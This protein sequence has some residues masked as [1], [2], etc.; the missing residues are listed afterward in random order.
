MNKDKGV[1]P[2]DQSWFWTEE[3]QEGER[4]ASEEIREGKLSPRLY[5]MEEME[6]YLSDRK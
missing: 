2:G 5:N 3:W 4:E 1:V 6:E